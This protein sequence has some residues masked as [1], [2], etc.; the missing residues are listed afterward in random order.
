MKRFLS[1]VLSTALVM[2]IAFVAGCDDEIASSETEI[3]R[4]DGT[5]VETEKKVE[6]KPDGSI[7]TTTEK[8]VDNTPDRDR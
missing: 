1:L 5:S 2:P 7:E 8:K 4:A 3:K 6:E